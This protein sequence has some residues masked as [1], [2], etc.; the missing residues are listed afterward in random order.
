M[1]HTVMEKAT[2]FLVEYCRAYKE[3]GANGVVIAE[4]V[5][6]LL[7]PALAEE[8]SE[9]YVRRIVEAV[10]DDSFLVVSTTAATPCSA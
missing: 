8:F 3:L 1:V 2:Q 7:S 6:G 5:T 10:Q 4:P 9:P